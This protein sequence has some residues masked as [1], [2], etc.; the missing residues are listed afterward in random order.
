M[1]IERYLLASS[2]VAIIAQTLV[3][4]ICPNCKL[5]YIPDANDLEILGFAPDADIELHKGTGCSV[6]KHTGYL[7]R[8]AVYEIMKLDTTARNLIMEQSNPEDLRTYMRKIGMKTL[9]ENCRELVLRGDTTLE[10]LLRIS[11]SLEG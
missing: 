2:V 9:Q 5:P 7:G 4:V 1:D 10:E 8:T 6:C 3:K 11:Y